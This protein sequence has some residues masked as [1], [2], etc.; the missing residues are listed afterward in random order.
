MANETTTTSLNDFV[1]TLIADA[2]MQLVRVGVMPP[3][4]R[5]QSLVGFPGKSANFT[6]W[7]ALA[8]SDVQ[9]GTEGTDYSTNKQLSSSV[10]SATVDEHLLMSTI[11]DLSRDSSVENVDEGAGILLGN[12]M[13]AKLDD[14]LVG[15]FSGFSNTV[16]GA[17]I[18]LSY[19]HFTQARQLLANANAPGP[20]YFVGHDKQIWGPKGIS[21]ILDATATSNNAQA[22][23]AA[24]ALQDAGS[25]SRFAGFSI[26][27]S[28]EINPNV[29]AGG[30][31]AGGF[32][33][34]QAI[35]LVD[36]GF[37][38]VELERNASMRGY[39]IVVQGLWKEVEVVDAYGVYAL[40]DVS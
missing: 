15:L 31:A 4:V 32:F 8:S 35:G 34:Q 25:I 11:T 16:A 9:A 33:S 27:Y 24:V 20:Y 13:A 3:K 26:D 39:E 1:D 2:I 18:T 36:K 29:A 22:T 17:G 38:N 14:D 28:S 23:P 5:R 40:S 37:L 7:D 12:A 21:R 6:K 30:D 10:V 19:D